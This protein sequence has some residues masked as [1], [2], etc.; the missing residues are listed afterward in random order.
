MLSVRT[1]CVDGQIGSPIPLSFGKLLYYQWMSGKSKVKLEG[2]SGK[3]ISIGCCF[4]PKFANSGSLAW[5]HRPPSRGALAAEQGNTDH[6]PLTAVELLG[7]VVIQHLLQSADLGLLLVQQAGELGDQVILE[8]LPSLH[9]LL[10]QTPQLDVLW[11]H[12]EMSGVS[13][14]HREWNSVTL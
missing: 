7:A 9:R 2:K 4:T 13:V 10:C 11:G 6:P 3:T 5:G 8:Q 14:C 1:D 12:G